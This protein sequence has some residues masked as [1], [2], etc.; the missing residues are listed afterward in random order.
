MI[1]RTINTHVDDFARTW[2]V[3]QEELSF[4]VA[5]YNPNREKQNSEAELKKTSDYDGYKEHTEKPVRK[6]AYWQSVIQ[7]FEEMIVNDVLPLQKR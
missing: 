6:L 3:P 5:N 2:W 7:A 4:M 1:Q